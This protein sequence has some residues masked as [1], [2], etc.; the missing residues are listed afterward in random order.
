MV[1]PISNA[2][3]PDP[4]DSSYPHAV[5]P[6]FTLR[7]TLKGHTKFIYDLAWS[8]DGNTLASGSEDTTIRLWDTHTG[9]HI[10]TLSRHS[11]GVYCVAWSPDGQTLASGA[12]DSTIRLWNPQAEPQFRTLS[13]HSNGVY[14]V[15]WSPD[16]KMF[17]SGAVDRTIRLWDAQS[18]KVLQVLPL[19]QGPIFSLVWSPKGDMIASSANDGIIRLWDAQAGK[20]LYALGGHTNNVNSLAWHPKGTILAS[21]SADRTIKL[22]N[23]RTMQLIGTL[24]GHTRLVSAVSFSADGRLLASKAHDGTVRLW[25]TDTREGVSILNES[26]EAKWITYIAFHPSLPILATLD[27]GDTIIRIWELNYDDILGTP[28]VPPTISYSNAKVV[29]VGDSGAGKSGLGLVLSGQQYENT[30]STHGRHIWTFANEEVELDE[31]RKE[32]REVL[33]WDLAGQPGYRL[34]HQ[35]YLNEVTVSLLV[36]DAQ[37]A[38]NPFAGVEYW[39]RALIQAQHMQG[40]TALPLKKFLVAARTDRG[41]VGV[42]RKRIDSLVKRLGFDGYFETSAKE[43]RQIAELREAI[44]KAIA[45][46]SLPKVSSTELFQRIKAFLVA[47]KERGQLLPKIDDLFNTFLRTNDIAD[48]P[49]NLRAQFETCIV[50]VESAGLIKQLS[51]GKRVLLQPELLDAYASALVNAVKNEPDGLGSMTQE[52]VQAGNFYIPSDARIQDK[53]DEKLLLIAIT[54]DLIRRDLVL[55]DEQFLIFPSQSTREIPDLPDPE[56]KTV[57]FNFEGPVSNIYATLAVRLSNSEVFK[58]KELWENAITYTANE[59]G[60]YGMY[61]RNIGDGRGELTLFFDKT[62]SEPLRLVFEDYIQT[63]LQRRALPESLKRRRIFICGTCGTPVTEQM[64]QRRRER[65]FN[66]LNCPVCDNQISLRDRE[67][68]LTAEPPPRVLEMEPRRR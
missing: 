57:V 2:P 56:G 44:H 49:E 29:L 42:G 26:F 18:G 35:L 1:T 15:S 12:E 30:D 51:F 50:L 10:H 68:R 61:L 59:S 7:H 22:W 65:G 6:G 58:N 67:E 13:E 53:D 46:K 8:P 9:Q 14:C 20:L 41:G 21:G 27:G 62:A 5:P 40:S 34:I 66:S 63:H 3:F 19:Q 28:S 38:T 25:R 16:S 23:T 43:G 55:R 52:R 32:T 31:R 45:W 47:E 36:F 24:E 17:V 11:A 48:Q 4:I 64:V 39:T 37:D 33:L 60:V 54:E